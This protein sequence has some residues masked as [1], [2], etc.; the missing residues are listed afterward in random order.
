[1]PGSACPLVPVRFAMLGKRAGHAWQAG[2]FRLQA[3]RA[4]IQVFKGNYLF[5]IQHQASSIRYLRYSGIKIFVI[6]MLSFLLPSYPRRLK[7]AVVRICIDDIK[8]QGLSIEFEEKPENF[9]ILED[10]TKTG[11]SDFPAALKFRVRAIRIREIVEIEGRFDTKAR[12]TCSRC[13]KQFETTL[14]ANFAITYTRKQ[15]EMATTAGVDGI[16]I[17]SEEAGLIAYSGRQIDLREVLQEQVVMS[18]PMQPIC[19]E[20]CRGLCSRCGAD[21]NAGECDCREEAIN[22]KFAGLKNLKLDKKR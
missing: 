8:D 20:A 21:L 11:E 19:A 10:I 14:G 18:I 12:L 17:G 13:L 3:R 9:P 6:N 5:L 1:M 16:E 7:E 4:G 2:R 22:I 15:S